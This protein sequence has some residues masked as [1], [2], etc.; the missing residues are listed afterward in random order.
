M[1]VQYDMDMQ[2]MDANTAFLQ[3]ELD[4]EI[5]MLQPEHYKKETQVCIKQVYI[6][7]SIRI[8]YGL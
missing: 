4:E 5:Y 2:Q 7:I 8:I 6:R 1:T 3:G